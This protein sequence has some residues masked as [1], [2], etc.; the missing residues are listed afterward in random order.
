MPF[1]VYVRVKLNTIYE[2]WNRVIP[3]ETMGVACAATPERSQVGGRSVRAARR[4]HAHH[5]RMSSTLRAQREPSRVFEWLLLF[6]FYSVS[7]VAALPPTATSDVLLVALLFKIAAIT[8]S[9]GFLFLSGSAA[10]K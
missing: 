1:L 7:V 2:L 9:T 6:L 3:F 8:A 10:G 5:S 4:T